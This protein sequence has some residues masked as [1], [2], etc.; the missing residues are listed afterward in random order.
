MPFATQEEYKFLQC[1]LKKKG[2]K[3]YS[4]NVLKEENTTL[5]FPSF[6][7]GDGVQNVFPS[8][9]EDQALR[10]C[11]LNTINDMRSNENHLL[12]LK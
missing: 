4:E 2:M 1:G 6:S 5:C 8:M 12:P 3:T 10:E 9:P 11:E 7:T